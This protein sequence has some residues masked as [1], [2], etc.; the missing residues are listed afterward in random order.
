MCYNVLH[1]HYFP[2]QKKIL[3]SLI[4]VIVALP[5]I[6][7]AGAIDAANAVFRE[8]GQGYTDRMVT[9]AGQG[10]EPE[11]GQWHVFAYD[12]K[13]PG[14][15]AHF[16]VRNGVVESA[17]VLDA[18]V[19]KQWAA[20][21]M[22]WRQ[23]RIDSDVAFRTANNAAINAR[24]GFD[25]VDY[26]LASP[27]EGGNPRYYMELRDANLMVVGILQIDAVTGAILNQQW[28]AE[29][30]RHPGGDRQDAVDWATVRDEMAKAGRNIGDAFRRMGRSIGDTFRGN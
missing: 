24:R 18:E 15:M 13:T 26:R 6:A 4:M 28:P 27:R 5:L 25:R 3:Q 8:Y 9:V 7:V 22:P 12:L 1:Q 20:P 19:S 14:L 11:P 23:V 30:Q 29:L 17:S 21:I 16:I 2:M 10:G